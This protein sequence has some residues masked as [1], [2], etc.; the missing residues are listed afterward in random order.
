[1][2]QTGSVQHLNL[3]FSEGKSLVEY[4][5]ENNYK[6]EQE[7]YESLNQPFIDPELRGLFKLMVFPSWEAMLLYC[8]Q[9]NGSDPPE[10]TYA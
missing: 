4:L 3:I 6:T 2:P 7:V 10:V 9:Y 5:S 8:I 1:M